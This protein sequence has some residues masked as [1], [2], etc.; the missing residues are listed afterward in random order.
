MEGE[1]KPPLLR[2]WKMRNWGREEEE[3]EEEEEKEEGGRKQCYTITPS[4]PSLPPPLQKKIRCGFFFA[5][6]TKQALLLP[7]YA[8]P[9]AS[10]RSS[11]KLAVL[12]EQKRTPQFINNFFWGGEYQEVDFSSF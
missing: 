2:D 8:L 11:N 9:P 5:A 12:G 4:S 10:L 1:I 3:E 6:A 7:C